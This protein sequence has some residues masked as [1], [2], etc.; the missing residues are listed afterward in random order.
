MVYAFLAFPQV[1]KLL[2]FSPRGILDRVLI[3]VLA[4]W[5]FLIFT[6]HLEGECKN[7]VGLLCVE[8]PRVVLGIMLP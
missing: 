3:S 4:S 5:A 8:S 6:S 7:F 2:K 1:N